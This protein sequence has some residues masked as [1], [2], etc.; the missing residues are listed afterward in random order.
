MLGLLAVKS[1]QPPIQRLEL[2]LFSGLIYCIGFGQ[3]K[4][5]FVLLPYQLEVGVR[6]ERLLAAFKCVVSS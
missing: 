1:T 3:N 4:D 2:E 6:Q 5:H